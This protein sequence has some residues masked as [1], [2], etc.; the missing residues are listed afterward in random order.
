MTVSTTVHVRN[1][2]TKATV[3]C[4]L[5]LRDTMV[6]TDD[7]TIDLPAGNVVALPD[8]AAAISLDLS[9]QMFSNMG[10]ALGWAVAVV[11]S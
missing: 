10:L 7:G 11:V 5:A 1:W 4:E 3:T 8:R 9:P 6:A 2:Q